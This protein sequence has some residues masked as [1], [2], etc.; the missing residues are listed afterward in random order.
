LFS[1]LQSSVHIAFPSAFTAYVPSP[2]VAP[3]PTPAAPARNLQA[4]S[5]IEL[6]I[7][8]RAAADYFFAVDNRNVYN[9]DCLLYVCYLL[10]FSNAQ[11]IP[12]GAKFVV[13][14]SN[15]VT[16]PISVY[17]LDEIIITTG[18]RYANRDSPYFSIDQL[19]VVPPEWATEKGIISP[20][21]ESGN[22]TMAIDA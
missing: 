3:A 12:A 1:D 22:P 4:G 2:P 5:G 6:T 18:A 19:A 11:T 13:T 9:E 16:N 7:D 10:E 20:E 14:V 21:D 15:L 8:G 17:P